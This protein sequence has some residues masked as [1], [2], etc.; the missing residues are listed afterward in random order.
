EQ[1][2]SAGVAATATAP[3]RSQAI[4]GLDTIDKVRHVTATLII[5]LGTVLDAPDVGDLT[6][7]PPIENAAYVMDRST[8]SVY[9]IDVVRGESKAFLTAGARVSRR[10]VGTPIKMTRGGGDVVILDDG[11]NLFRWRPADAKGSGT[12]AAIRVSGEAN[13][14]DDVTDIATFD[15]NAELYNFYVVDPSAQQ[16]L[17]S[18]PDA[19]GG[20]YGRN[21]AGYLAA[22]A[23]LEAV[24]QVLV[25]GD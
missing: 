19:D 6:R 22:P 3:L 5:D 24:R 23:P 18:S 17:R 20:G 10:E 12:L 2:R 16:L 14:G 4:A 21:P 1:A 7:R 9:R 13:W 8:K 25:D 11:G 15:L